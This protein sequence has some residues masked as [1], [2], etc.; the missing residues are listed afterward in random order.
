MTDSHNK[1]IF[2]SIQPKFVEKILSKEKTIELRRKF[3]QILAKNTQ[4]LI[5][6]SS[7]QQQ[8]LATATIQTVEKLPT[9]KIWKQYA[10]ET[11]IDKV[12][13]DTYFHNALFGFAIQLSKV[14]K[15]RQPLSRK[16]LKT[17]YGITPPQSYIYLNKELF[18]DIITQR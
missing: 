3:P 13:F 9:S 4:L 15:I 5:Y 11:C 18:E 1:Y 10:S 16:D 8:V 17:K 6:S 12:L 14:K 2:I 7:P